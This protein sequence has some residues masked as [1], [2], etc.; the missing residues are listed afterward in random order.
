M[1][2]A[3]PCSL[4]AGGGSLGTSAAADVG[5][6][7]RLVHPS[8]ADETA[9]E[10]PALASLGLISPSATLCCRFSRSWASIAAATRRDK[11][12][13]QQK[14]CM[15]RKSQ[16]AVPRGEYGKR[17]A[18]KER[19]EDLVLHTTT[20]WLLGEA[21]LDFLCRWCLAFGQVALDPPT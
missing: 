21:S 8:I 15:A 20:E 9:D 5:A 16:Y 4:Y 11:V 17:I 13:R 12:E 7:G 2:S 6:D 3:T 10:R 18:K 1:E 19:L 14:N